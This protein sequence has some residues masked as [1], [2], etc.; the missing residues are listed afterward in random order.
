MTSSN[1][2]QYINIFESRVPCAPPTMQ[3][4]YYLWIHEFDRAMSNVSNGMA[5]D[6]VVDRWISNFRV[7]RTRSRFA[8]NTDKQ[9]HG[10]SADLLARKWGIGI[11]KANNNLQY[12]TQNNLISALKT[13]THQYRTYFL[14]QRL[15]RLNCRFYTDTL[16]SKYKHIIGN[17]CDHIFTYG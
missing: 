17:T 8:I 12:T 2:H 4:R 15:C 3:C 6:L 11:Y 13:L 7:K 10:I 14:S 5:Q 9:H 1:F 16:F